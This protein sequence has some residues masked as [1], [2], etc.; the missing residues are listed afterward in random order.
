[1]GRW[2]LVPIVVLDWFALA[3][4]AVV[5]TAFVIAVVGLAGIAAALVVRMLGRSR[6]AMGLLGVA[7]LLG[8]LV[9]FGID[10]FPGSFPLIDPWWPDVVTQPQR[11]G[12]AYWQLLALGVE[13]GGFGLL[14]TLLVVALTGQRP[15]RGR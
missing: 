4:H 5:V 13:L 1:V 11:V 9:L 6:V 2:L 15:A 14:A 3:P 8:G 7:L 12:S 10:P